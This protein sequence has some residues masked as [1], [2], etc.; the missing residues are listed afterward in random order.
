MQELELLLKV[1]Q[2]YYE[3]GLTQNEIAKKL[4][5]SRSNISRLLTQ[6]REAGIVEIKVHYP[7]ERKRRIVYSDH[8]IGGYLSESSVE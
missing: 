3:Q 6:A 4:F 2:L 8:E 7:F 5:I 1:A